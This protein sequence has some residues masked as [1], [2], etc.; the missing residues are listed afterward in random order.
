MTNA[1]FSLAQL[2][3]MAGYLQKHLAHLCNEYMCVH[4]AEAVFSTACVP[5]LRQAS[6]YA[7]INLALVSRPL[8][9][10]HLRVKVKNRNSR[11]CSGSVHVLSIAMAGILTSA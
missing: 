10:L 5:R 11:L 2:R 9:R 7:R 4:V 6:S 1:G 8:A 3:L